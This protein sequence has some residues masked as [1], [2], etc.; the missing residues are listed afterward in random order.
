MIQKRKTRKLRQTGGTDQ[1]FREYAIQIKNKERIDTT[2]LKSFLDTVKNPLH[3]VIDYD[4]NGQKYTLNEYALIHDAGH[5]IH[6]VFRKYNIN[7]DHLANYSS[8]VGIAEPL[9]ILEA[10]LVY[11]KY[12]ENIRHALEQIQSDYRN[13]K[14]LFRTIQRTK[15]IPTVLF[16]GLDSSNYILEPLNESIYD[17][18]T[19][20][21]Y[22]NNMYRYLSNNHNFN[23]IKE[24]VLLGIRFNKPK[25][26][27]T[28]L[29][30]VEQSSEIVKL[31]FNDATISFLL[32]QND[33]KL[34][35]A[36]I[37]VLRNIDQPILLEEIQ[38]SE[39][40]LHEYNTTKNAKR[41]FTIVGRHRLRD[42]ISPYIESK[43]R[44]IIRC[45]G[46]IDNTKKQEFQFP[47]DQLCFFVNA[48]ETLG[49]TCVVSKRTEMM[50]CN[51]N[52][53]DNM[54]CLKSDNNKIITEPMKFVFDAG[55]FIGKR[56]MFTGIYI[57]KDGETERAT[58][59]EISED[60][61]Y[62]MN[63]IIQLCEN[64]C[65][66]R[67]LDPSNVDIMLFSCRARIGYP[68]IITRVTPKIAA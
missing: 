2:K 57:C 25:F 28:I 30:K 33:T 10:H 66:I 59:L 53:D 6:S 54:K 14:Y 47:F 5:N 44:I 27:S 46:V 7:L 41:F 32:L 24:L 67:K 15:G 23:S 38:M 39:Q 37:S 12:D 45:H 9:T 65:H 22:N 63:D 56:N 31:I 49:E 48:G 34:F 16:F 13:I 62:N 17:T 55:F 40:L 68:K 61:P 26:V 51:G 4:G 43:I 18:I 64:A 20:T 1:K 50:I 11:S 36:M 8:L 60:I 35:D 58:E 3:I 21:Y 42:I 52:Y 29:L 19:Q